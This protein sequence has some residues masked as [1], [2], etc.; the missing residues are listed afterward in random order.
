[1]QLCSLL[2]SGQQRNVCDHPILAPLCSILNVRITAKS[3]S[4]V[5]HEIK[6][7]SVYDVQTNKSADEARKA[8]AGCSRNCLHVKLASKPHMREN[9]NSIQSLSYY[10]KALISNSYFG[11]MKKPTANDYKIIEK[12]MGGSRC[13]VFCW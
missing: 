10:I 13:T 5:P 7:S 8:T 2:C 3:V 1:M 9:G 6:K 4:A 11:F 12:Q